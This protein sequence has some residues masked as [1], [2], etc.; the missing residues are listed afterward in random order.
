MKRIVL[1]FVLFSFLAVTIVMTNGKVLQSPFATVR[2]NRVT[3][4][5]FSG[6]GIV[7]GQSSPKEIAALELKEEMLAR[8][9]RA[10]RNEHP[11]SDITDISSSSPKEITDSETETVFTVRFV[12]KMKGALLGLNTYSVPVR[13][14]AYFGYVNRKYK[15][16]IRQV[17]AGDELEKAE[18]DEARGASSSS[19][20]S[21][22]SPSLQPIPGKT[23]YEYK[24]TF[25][26]VLDGVVGTYGE[27]AEMKEVVIAED[28]NNAREKVKDKYKDACYEKFKYQSGITKIGIVK[29][30]YV[31]RLR[32]VEVK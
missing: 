5:D 11:L 25:Q 20:S 30:Y 26:C 3:P 12:V 6:F 4:A 14:K 31:E 21:S 1:R 15:W 19:R 22:P 23:L 17:L 28:E 7:V 29:T 2:A 13:I 10:A 18:S 8:V 32:K 24:V 27:T 16:E 9:R